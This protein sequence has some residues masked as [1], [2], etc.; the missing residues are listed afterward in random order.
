M[1]DNYKKELEEKG[2]IHLKIKVHAG[3]KLTRIKSILSDGTIKIDIA[4]APEDGKAND[5]L[6]ELLKKEFNLAKSQVEIIMGKFSSD[7]V[8]QLKV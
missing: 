1:L 6:I 8:V 4:K 3:A 7:K 2:T 5:V